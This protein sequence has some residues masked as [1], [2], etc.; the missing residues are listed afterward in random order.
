MQQQQQQGHSG[1][2]QGPQQQRV[3]QLLRWTQRRAQRRE[4]PRFG[5]GGEGAWR[6]REAVVGGGRPG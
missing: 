4:R 2:T 3:Q 6:G 1:P 5:S